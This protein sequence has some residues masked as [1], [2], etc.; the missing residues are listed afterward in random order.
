MRIIGL[1]LSLTAT[2]WA[3]SLT[4][5]G[6][7]TEAA[8]FRGVT[9]MDMLVDW[10]EATVVRAG[11]DLVALEGFSFGSKG[12]SV[13]QIYGW[14]WVCRLHLHRA[15]VA[16]AE[17]PP[18][19]LKRFATGKGTAAKPDMRMELYKRT[20]VDIADDNAVDA[21]WLWALARAAYGFPVIDVPK[22]HLEAVDKVEWPTR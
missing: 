21:V 3:T 5:F 18:S 11:P 19:V 13:D 12:S 4:K 10:L 6:V 2:G 9:R 8:P 14:G 20:N 1:D 17:I 7:N 16:Y 15:G 22:T